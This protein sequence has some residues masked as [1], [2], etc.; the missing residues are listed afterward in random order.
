MEFKFKLEKYYI[1]IYIYIYVRVQ[2]DVVLGLFDRRRLIHVTK[3]RQ[4]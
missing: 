2:L 1:Y 3:G 4:I